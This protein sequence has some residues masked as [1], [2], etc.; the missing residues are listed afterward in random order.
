MQTCCDQ[1]MKAS[2]PAY[3]LALLLLCQLQQCCPPLLRRHWRRSCHCSRPWLRWLR[4]LVRNVVL[5][6]FIRVVALILHWR[7]VVVPKQ[8]CRLLRG[9]HLRSGRPCTQ[10]SWLRHHRHLLHERTPAQCSR[11]HLVTQVIF[12]VLHG[13]NQ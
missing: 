11:P 12:K 3:R 1:D 10:A 7:V 2:G 13:Y 4:W 5:Q 8:I 6:V 9:L